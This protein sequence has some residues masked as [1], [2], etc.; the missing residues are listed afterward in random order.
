MRAKLP[1]HPVRVG[2]GEA[3]GEPE[4]MHRAIMKGIDDLPRDMV[5]ALHEVH[6][7]RD[8]ADALATVAAEVARHIADCTTGGPPVPGLA[9]GGPPVVLPAKYSA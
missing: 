7:E 3:T 2:I 6:H 4:Q 5:R 1:Q 8:V 9:T